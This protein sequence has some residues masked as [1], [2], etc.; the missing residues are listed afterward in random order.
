MIINIEQY[1]YAQV[2][3]YKDELNIL[4][5]SWASLC[6]KLKVNQLNECVG[7]W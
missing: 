3:E 7:G 2:V 5:E 6:I 4:T 1:S